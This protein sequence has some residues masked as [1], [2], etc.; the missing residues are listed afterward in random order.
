MFTLDSSGPVARI[1]LDRPAFRNAVALDQWVVLAD[2]VGQAIDGGA[3][4]LI[5]R[6]GAPNIFSAGADLGD[7]DGL[8]ADPALRGRFRTGMARAFDAL[9]GAPIATI[10]AIDGGCYGA[11]VALALACDIRIAG[12][13]AQF[14][15]TPAKVGIVYPAC[16]VARLRAL[17]GPGQAARLLLSGMTIEADEALSIGLVEERAKKAD[18]AALALAGTIAANS[19]SSVAGLKRIIAGDGDS[20]TLFEDAFGSSDFR[21]GLAA[22]RARRRPV[23]P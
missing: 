13:R 17:V 16:D 11:G 12:D 3:R 9:A 7:L 19:R 14:G 23:F 15:I 21:E 4:A 1:S 5:V 6:S 18:D 2:L 10:A 20:D 8:S 22:F